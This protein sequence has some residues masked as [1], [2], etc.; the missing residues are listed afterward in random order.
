[1]TLY[2]NAFILV[3]TCR[4]T[5]IP[6]GIYRPDLQLQAGDVCPSVSIPYLGSEGSSKFLKTR[7]KTS[8]DASSSYLSFLILAQIVSRA[9]KQ[10][11]KKTRAHEAENTNNLRL[12]PGVHAISCLCPFLKNR[13]EKPG[14]G[15]LCDVFLQAIL[16][17]LIAK[18][19]LDLLPVCIKIA[20]EKFLAN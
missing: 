17:N 19:G 16:L 14:R 15:Q 2:F 3:I 6:Y 5:P 10:E 8:Y 11:S 1:M 9:I 13:H 4:R 18:G 20:F 7:M 12:E